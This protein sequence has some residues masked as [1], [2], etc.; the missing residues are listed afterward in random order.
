MQ[1]QQTRRTRR[2][3]CAGFTLIELAIVIVIIGG[4]IAIVAPKLK[5]GGTEARA[6]ALYEFAAAATNNWRILTTKCGTY[7][8]TATSLIPSSAGALNALSVIV[9]GTGVRA[10][11]APCYADAAM[12]PLRAKAQGNTSD[13]FKVQG[14]GVTW[15]GGAN[16]GPITFVYSTVP[17]EIVL[18]LYKRYNSTANAST[19]SSTASLSATGDSTDPVVQYGVITSGIAATV[20]III[21]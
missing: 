21:N 18:S 20:S 12:A 7:G 19:A 4:L 15:S 3:L 5:G 10:A 17:A 6:T 16:N 9:T 14:E 2:R 11:Y 13:G 8:D 1:E